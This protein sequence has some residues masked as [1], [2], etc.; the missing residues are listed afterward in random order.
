MTNPDPD[1][2]RVPG[3]N[4]AHLLQPSGPRR[5]PERTRRRT[6]S[7]LLRKPLTY[8][9]AVVV[10]TGI[11]AGFQQLITATT[12]RTIEQAFTDPLFAFD[13]KMLE[14]APYAWS[15]HVTPGAI[16]DAELAD[17]EWDPMYLG[18]PTTDWTLERGGSFAGWGQWEIVL[19]GRRD[20][21]VSI[22][23]L[24]PTEI[25][26]EDPGT[27]TLFPLALEGMG[28]KIGLA[29]E[30]DEPGAQLKQL[31]LDEPLSF[32][33]PDL[34]TL[35]AFSNGSTITLG[36]GE[37]EVITF[38]AHADERYCEFAL[39]VEFLAEGERQTSRIGP[40][41]PGHFS[42]AP[43]LDLADYESVVV[44]WKVCVDQQPHAVTGPQA[45]A[46]YEAL[47]SNPGTPVD[48]SSQW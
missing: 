46:I 37:K 40:E 47:D 14:P 48:C 20:E 39:A 24:Y 36:R 26:C 12:S 38:M 18:L 28:E 29:V 42:V 23:D 1:F 6:L 8:V 5:P 16:T 31:P 33:P 35:P 15:G 9:V 11:F 27:G 3:A 43:V 32:D 25:E 4:R 19:E 34:E 21:T 45:A 44:P 41:R 7:A 30:I 10:G 2:R 17:F 13:V 22:T